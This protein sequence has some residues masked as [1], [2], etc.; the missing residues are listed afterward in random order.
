MACCAGGVGAAGREPM[1][2]K[3]T[4]FLLDDRASLSHA[5]LGASLLEQEGLHSPAPRKRLVAKQVGPFVT[6][7]AQ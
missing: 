6:W 5:G 3:D 2:P 7:H 1:S 4:S